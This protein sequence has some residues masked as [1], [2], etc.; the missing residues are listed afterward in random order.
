MRRL[1]QI[2]LLALPLVAQTPSFQT[3]ISL[4]H[5]SA[6]ILDN[7]GRIVGNLSPIDFRVYDEDREQQI[8]A[9]D[10]DREPLDL[11]L[12]FDVSGSMRR[13]AKNIAAAAHTALRELHPGDRVAIMSFA[14]EMISDS[15]F[16]EDL[17]EVAASV[18]RVLNRKARGG[19]HIDSSINDART[20]FPRGDR[21][22]AIV[23]ITDNLAPRTLPQM[24]VIRDLWEADA[25]LGSLL[26]KPRVTPPIQ[27]LGFSNGD[28]GGVRQIAEMTGGD[29]LDATDLS[30][31]F[32]EMLRRVRNRYSIYYKKPEGTPG[33]TRSIRVRL[34]PDAA[35]RFPG[36]HVRARRGYVLTAQ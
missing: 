13:H 10:S 11:I 12:L 17:H 30:L 19:T 3:G 9:F 33:A 27:V 14:A 34:S 20:R 15:G 16:T 24:S 31:A 25:I 2:A 1:F 23:I 35:A 6:E 28:I 7:N 4:V 5:V 8:V 21:R 18:D 36:A 32:P 29:T 22:R 26:F